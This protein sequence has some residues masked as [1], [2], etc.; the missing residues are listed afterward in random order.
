MCYTRAFNIMILTAIMVIFVEAIKYYASVWFK[1]HGTQKSHAL[2]ERIPHAK[3]QG[4]LVCDQI[5][6]MKDLFNSNKQ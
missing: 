2:V 1:I 5:L 6:I 3:Q 4:A